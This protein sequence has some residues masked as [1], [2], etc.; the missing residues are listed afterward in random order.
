MNEIKCPKCGEIFAI[1]DSG[2]RELVKEVKD[3]EFEKEL[4]VREELLRNESAIKLERVR[5]ELEALKKEI[6]Q[7]RDNIEKILTK[8]LESSA[9]KARS[10]YSGLEMY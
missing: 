10:N 1:D 4:K 3:K 5:S 8:I 2:Y 6:R 7:L 9:S